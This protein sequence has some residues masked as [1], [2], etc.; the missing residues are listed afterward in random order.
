MQIVQSR[1]DFWS[2]YRLAA[3]A[4]V[5]GT[6]RSLADEGPPETTTSGVRR[7]PQHLRRARVHRRGP[8]ARGRVHRYPLHSRPPCRRCRTRR[9]DFDLETAAWV[10][11]QLDAGEPITALAG[12]HPGCYEL[13][14]HEPIR[15]HQR[16]EGQAGRHRPAA[17]LRAG[18]C[19]SRS[20]RRRSGWIPD[21]HRLDRQP[22]GNFMELFAEGKVD[23]FLGFPPEPQ[24]L[25]ARKIGRVI[26]NLGTDK[27]WSQYFCC[28]SVRQ[29]GVRP[30]SSGRHQALPARHPQGRRHLRDRAG[31]GRATLVDRGFTRALRLRA[32]DADRDPVRQLARVR[33]GGLDAVLCAAPARGRH[34]QVQPERRSSPRAPTGAS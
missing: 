23:A 25:R 13:F 15:S 32:P 17:R 8:A 11:S 26:L 6:R 10:V 33:P 34:D 31:A 7:I 5:L 18:I 9:L 29:Q 30:R 19:S 21:G 22:A 1:R 3:A 2:A 20:L 4:G 16:P 24:E 27:P 28:I 12:V 14:A